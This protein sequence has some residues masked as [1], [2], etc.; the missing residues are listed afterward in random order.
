LKIAVLGAS[1]MLGSMLVDVLSKDFELVATVR[2]KGKIDCSKSEVDWHI[3]DVLDQSCNWEL[4]SIVDG[5]DWMINAIG[6]IPQ[7][8]DERH[9]YYLN[10]GFPEKLS[11]LGIPVIQIATDCVYSGL[12]GDY[13]ESDPH[14]YQD[15]Y[16][17][18]KSEGEIR[19]PTMHYLRCSIVGIE[20]FGEYSLL[21][22]FISQPR[23]ATFYG[24]TN[25]IWNGVTALH[26]ARICRGIIENGIELPHLQHIVPLYPEPKEWVLDHARFYFRRKDI[27]V[28]PTEAEFAINRSLA[29]NNP[30]LNRRLWAGAG[31]VAPPTIRQMIKELAEW[32]KEEKENGKL[33]THRIEQKGG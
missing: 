15:D 33:Y 3:L 28:K 30:V 25:H 31:Y 4:G 19:A 7:R 5:V 9:M 16:G 14:D 20:P 29:T 1:G 26:F 13:V 12:K 6:A 18:S 17:K 23:G 21:K 27:T 32:Y 22:K 11:R 8:R 10:A 2:D 24:Y